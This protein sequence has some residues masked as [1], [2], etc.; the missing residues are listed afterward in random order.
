MEVT[1]NDRISYLPGREEPLSSEVV[2]IKGDTYTWIYDVGAGEEALSYINGLEGEKYVALS[3]FHNDHTENLPKIAYQKIY[4][5]WISARPLTA[6]PSC[7]TVGCL[8][9]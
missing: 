9:S 5:G 3:H 2:V 7:L 4:Q 1:I 6:H 8:W